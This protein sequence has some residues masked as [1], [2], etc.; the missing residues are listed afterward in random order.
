[1][2]KHAITLIL[3]LPFIA[4]FS[5][6]LNFEVHGTY[7]RSIKKEK[8]N[9]P[10]TLSDITSDYPASWISDYISAEITATCNG[11]VLKAVSPND[12]LSS[13]Q[14][15]LLNTADLATDIV[16]DVH[17][18]YKNSVT[19]V[20]EMNDMHFALTV[21]P[22]IEAEYLGGNQLMTQYL[23]ENTINKISEAKSKT[24]QAATVK[25]TIDE[26]GE[27]A[28]VQISKTSGDR[29]ID[30]LLLKAIHKMPKW[31]PAE[32]SKGIK[33]KQDF[34]FNIGSGGC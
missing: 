19:D 21:V 2:K 20:K 16:I 11:K 30:K 24:L 26:E 33:V 6:D 31:R 10:K 15:N 9:N 7:A 27:I 29:K 17:Y 23:K 1:M 14:I 5:Q 4:G 13:E 25:F 8:L 12:A 34:V 32:N 3:L 28:N 18:W 22:E